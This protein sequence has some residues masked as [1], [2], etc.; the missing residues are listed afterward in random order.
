[1]AIEVRLGLVPLPG[2]APEDLATITERLRSNL[3]ALDLAPVELP[4]DEEGA[5]ADSKGL[6]SALVVRV[7]PP[8][9][10]LLRQVV[11]AVQTWAAQNG[12]TVE[13]TIA[14]QTLKVS[15]TT[16]E[17]LIEAFLA[18]HAPT[19]SP[20]RRT[21]R[22]SLSV[23]RQDVRLPKAPK[24]PSHSRRSIHRLEVQ[25]A[26]PADQLD[27]AVSRLE[28]AVSRLDDA[29][30]RFVRAVV[31]PGLL[32]FNPP[33][34]M[35]QG[36]TERVEVGIARSPELREALEA[37]LRGRGEPQFEGIN[38][39]SVMGVELRGAAF[40]VTSLG[41]LEQLVAPIARWEF[42]VRPYRA[43]YQTLTLCISLHVDSPITT[44]GRIAVPVLERQIRIRVDV[45][46]GTRRFFAK[47]WQWLV[48][49]ALALGGGL[50]AWIKLL[51]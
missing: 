21:R 32:T 14:G 2:E 22:D 29:M 30:S 34:E 49:T 24:A 39:S 5:P 50:A 33:A 36:K 42:D 7:A 6:F 37:G 12:R 23:P 16:S 43:G 45:A 9:D 38:T 20:A 44:G 15:A 18:R 10:L 31:K 46:Y 4:S 8:P 47:N 3:L 25:R 13:I 26:A 28:D 40:E 48:A 17:E 51:H 35:I 1:M 11:A 19:P 41:P 27:D